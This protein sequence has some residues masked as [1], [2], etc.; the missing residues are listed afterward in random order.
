MEYSEL[1]VT[2]K[3]YWVQPLALHRHPNSRTLGI[4]EITI[5]TF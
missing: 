2:H 4:P 5:Q 1:E 3:Y